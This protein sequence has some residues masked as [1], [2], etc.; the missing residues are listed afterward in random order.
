M[1]S[2]HRK[3]LLGQVIRIRPKIEK[4]LSLVL[5]IFI[6]A[7]MN[8]LSKTFTPRLKMDANELKSATNLDQS[9]TILGHLQLTKCTGICVLSPAHRSELRGSDVYLYIV[10]EKKIWIFFFKFSHGMCPWMSFAWIFPGFVFKIKN[11]KLGGL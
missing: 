5:D 6:S 7:I 8:H 1:W 10:R 3:Y 4:K 11:K 9:G 2:D